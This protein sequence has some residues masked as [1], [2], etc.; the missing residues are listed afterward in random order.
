M[1]KAQQER[2][3][4]SKLGADISG[5]E[6]TLSSFIGKKT[7]LDKLVPYSDGYVALTE[8]GLLS[9]KDL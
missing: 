1:Q 9:M 3:T 2:E 6:S 4:L 5:K 8:T 7:L